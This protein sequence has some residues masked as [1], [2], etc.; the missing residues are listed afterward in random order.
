M[1]Q[2]R[3]INLLGIMQITVLNFV[4]DKRLSEIVDCK[5][6]E[7]WLTLK[8]KLAVKR[9]LWNTVSYEALR[10]DELRWRVGIK[11]VNILS[12]KD[13]PPEISRD[14]DAFIV[15]WFPW[16]DGKKDKR[17]IRELKR[18]VCDIVDRRQKPYLWICFW[19][20]LLAEAFWWKLEVMNREIIWPRYFVLNDFWIEDSLFA[21][22]HTRRVW[23]ICWHKRKLKTVWEWTS[24]LWWNADWW[25]QI[26]KIGDRAWWFQWHP[27][28]D[29][30]RT[31]WV[32]KLWRK[33]VSARWNNPEDV[34]IQLNNPLFKN[35]ASGVIPAFLRE[36]IK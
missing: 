7:K 14:W 18:I 22:L 19:H 36:V 4:D 20:Q 10:V 3:R 15:W 17:L 34:L 13:I 8:E 35:S 5:W 33:W 16:V 9:T 25:N 11:V 27:E 29:I 30:N 21:Q 24:T 6:G 1:I 32:V 31:T 2:W 26:I 12:E 23:T 28:F